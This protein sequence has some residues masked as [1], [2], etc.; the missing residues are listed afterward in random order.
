[1]EIFEFHMP[2]HDDAN[3][4][5]YKKFKNWV[6]LETY[7]KLTESNQSSVY[8]EFQIAFFHKSSTDL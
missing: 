5:A 3:N 4:S 2:F 7:K 8:Q 6:I 1:M